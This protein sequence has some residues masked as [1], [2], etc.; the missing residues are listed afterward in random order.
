[1]NFAY[2]LVEAVDTL[3]TGVHLANISVFTSCVMT[4]AVFDI[5]KTVV[6]G[7]VIE[8]EVKYTSGTIRY[9]QLPVVSACH[10]LT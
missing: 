10:A 4:L 6:D 8:P 9:A 2:P 3:S 1:M 7:K 5:S